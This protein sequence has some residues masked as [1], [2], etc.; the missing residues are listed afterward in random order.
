[1]SRGDLRKMHDAEPKTIVDP[2]VKLR[3]KAAQAIAEETWRQD[4]RRANPGAS[5]ADRDAAW[6]AARGEE[7]KKA[8]RVLA[9]L[10]RGGFRVVRAAP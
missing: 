8:R 10:E 6:A 9:A 2:E 4:W 7:L 3:R 1:M 5:R